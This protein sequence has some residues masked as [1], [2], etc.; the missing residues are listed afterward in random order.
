M[1]KVELRVPFQE[2]DVQELSKAAKLLKVKMSEVIRQ[3]VL[4]S[5]RPVSDRER[6][7]Y[8][9]EQAA[10]AVPG[11]PRAQLEQIVGTTIVALHHN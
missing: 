4:T 5:H 8:C 10:R 1:A 9:V 6:Y 11:I 2:K 7:A 3:R